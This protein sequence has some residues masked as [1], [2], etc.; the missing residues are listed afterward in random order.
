ML[1]ILNRSRLPLVSP[2]IESGPP[3]AS[4]NTQNMRGRG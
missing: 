4:H 3:K 1:T 2:T